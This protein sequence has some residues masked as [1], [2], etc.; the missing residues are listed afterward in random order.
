VAKFPTTI[1]FDDDKKELW[2]HEG[3]VTGAQIR[4]E[5]VRVK[6][7]PAPASGAGAKK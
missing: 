4:R 6:I 2:R 5:L 7:E 3:D 1:I